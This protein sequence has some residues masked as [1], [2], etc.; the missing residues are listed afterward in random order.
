MLK[1]NALALERLTAADPVLVD[2]KPAY[3]VLE[4]LTPT[5]FLHAGPPIAFEDMCAPMQGAVYCALLNE[6]IAKTVEE[7]KVMAVDGTV[8]YAPC[9]GY[10]AVGPMTGLTTW[11]MPLWVVEDRATGR[12]SYANISEGVGV[13]LRFGE[14]GQKTLERLAW[15]REYLGPLL[16]RLLR[17]AGGIDLAPMM[18]QGLA[19]GDELHMRNHAGTALFVKNYAWLIAKLAGDQAER[20]LKFIGVGHDQFFLNIA[21]AANKLAADLADGVPGSTMVTAIARN[22]VEVG[23]RISGLPGR[24]F[25]APAPLVK[26]L[27]FPGYTEEED[28]NPDLGDSAIMEV[29]GF[30][31][32]AMAAAPAIVRL[33]GIPDT[34]EAFA[35]TQLMRTITVGEHQK[36]T[37][38]GQNFA[39]LPLGIDIMKVVETG[40]EP[41]LN[42]A[43]ASKVPGVGMIGAGLSRVPFKAFADALVAFDEALRSEGK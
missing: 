36:Y 28:A 8:T 18:A 20:V 30:G 7:A 11:S 1:A 40:T 6:G 32:F 25:T 26:G 35:F 21:M 10:G 34:D 17:E 13:G 33:I 3:E 39:G 31:G 29:N 12:R 4:G 22:G 24:W 37:I 41:G 2:V 15:M 38:P 43:I 23:I 16:S 19:M 14:Y 9:H 42:T 5:T 27:Y